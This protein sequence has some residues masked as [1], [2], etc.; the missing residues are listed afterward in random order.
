MLE[1]N[2]YQLFIQMTASNV[3]NTTP[4]AIR[5][6]RLDAIRYLMQLVKATLYDVKLKPIAVCIWSYENWSY[7]T[8]YKYYCLEVVV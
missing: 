3:E 2:H 5:G 7:P 8:H 4:R 6:K 1:T